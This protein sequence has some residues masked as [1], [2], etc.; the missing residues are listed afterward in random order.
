[1]V[2]RTSAEEDFKM[3][4]EIWFKMN[5]NFRGGLNPVGIQSHNWA[6]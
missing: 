5:L 1:M 4:G 6:I 2:F 3:G